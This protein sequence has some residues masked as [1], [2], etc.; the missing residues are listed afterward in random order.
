MGAFQNNP[1]QL[2]RASLKLPKI[3]CWL[4]SARR[5]SRQ[6]KQWRVVHVVHPQQSYGPVNQWRVNYRVLPASGKQGLGWEWSMSS[7]RSPAGQH[8]DGD[9]DGCSSVLLGLLRN[10]HTPCCGPP[11]T[12]CN[13]AL[14]QCFKIFWSFSN[15]YAQMRLI[16]IM[17]TTNE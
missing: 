2:L 11:G 7:L 3:R 4:A 17:H 16:T 14:G 10:A 13:L 9:G 12:G 8:V 5:W 1:H 15:I 6:G